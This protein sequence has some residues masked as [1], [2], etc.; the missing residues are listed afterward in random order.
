MEPWRRPPAAGSLQSLKVEAGGE[1]RRGEEEPLVR[2][3]SFDGE[4]LLATADGGSVRLWS[5]ERRR[6]ICSLKTHSGRDEI[7]AGERRLDGVCVCCVWGGG[8]AAHGRLG[9]RRR[10]R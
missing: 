8:G 4:G 5:M 6:R 2:A 7:H 10:K 1:R 9:E 3:L